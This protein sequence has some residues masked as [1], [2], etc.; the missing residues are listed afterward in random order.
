MKR[1]NDEVTALHRCARPLPRE[2][3][4]SALPAQGTKSGASSVVST[5]GRSKGLSFV[6]RDETMATMRPLWGIA[7]TGAVLVACSTS[8]GGAASKTDAP[9]DVPDREI[10]RAEIGPEGGSLTGEAVTIDVPP[11]AVTERRVFSINGIA[12]ARIGLPRKVKASRPGAYALGPD[13]VEFAKPVT[14][15]I[16]V[17]RSLVD[18]L[19]PGAFVVFRSEPVTNFWQKKDAEVASETGE[20][21]VTTTHFSWWTDGALTDLSCI[22]NRRTCESTSPPSEPTKPAMDCHIPF[23]GP[24]IHCKGTGPGNTAPFEC[25]CNGKPE[26]IGTFERLPHDKFVMEHARLCGGACPPLGPTPACIVPTCTGGAAGQAWTC[27]AE[28]LGVAIACSFEPGKSASCTCN[29]GSDSFMIAG[30]PA[31]LPT[32][33]ELQEIMSERCG[34][35]DCRPPGSPPDDPPPPPPV[36]DDWICNGEGAPSDRPCWG[37]SV[38]TCRDG[39]YYDYQCDLVQ[40]EPQECKCLVD[41]VVTKTVTSSCQDD[42]WKACGFPKQYGE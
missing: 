22:T 5:L 25:R 37:L 8:D 31:G 36:P 28:R 13:D 7:L 21:V 42:T 29:G 18:E 39:H 24:G 4:V 15:R 19:G 3:L 6:R 35:V 34:A 38:T 17:E 27:R 16:K 12:E 41:G 23:D 9:P 30:G 11:G 32:D 20:I 40:P 26:I 2:R 10:A 1:V 33:A 14:V